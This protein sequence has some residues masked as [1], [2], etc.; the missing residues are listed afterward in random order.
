[1]VKPTDKPFWQ[2][3]S[4]NPSEMCVLPVPLLPTA[5]TFSRRAMY[6]QRASARTKVLLS[7]GDRREIETVEA[8]HCREPCLLDAALDHPALPLDQFEF[9]QA[10]QVAGVVDPLG[11]ALPGEL[12]VFA[13]EGRQLECLEMMRE[14]QLRLL[15]LMTPRRAGR[16]RPW[17][18]SSRPLPLAGRDRPSGRA[19]VAGARSGTAP[20]A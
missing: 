12:V 7:E 2:A 3:A 19:S 16:D 13:Q 18:R 17:P 14:Q 20:D 11:G 8:L 4:P 1:M 9:G 10:Q 5:M 15:S 6:S